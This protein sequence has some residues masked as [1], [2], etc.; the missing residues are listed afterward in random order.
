MLTYF[1]ERDR[2]RARKGQREREIQNWSR[3]QALS[4]Q[5]RAWHGARTH[6]PGDHDL[7]RSWT[8][9]RLSHPGI[10]VIHL[11]I[12]VV[13]LYI[14]LNFLPTEFVCEQWFF[15]NYFMKVFSGRK[16]KCIFLD[17][18]LVPEI[19]WAH[20]TYWYFTK[21]SLRNVSVYL[22]NSCFVIAFWTL[23]TFPY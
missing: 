3:L 13:Y 7:S 8:P 12:L 11:L 19:W 23:H 17:L 20:F 16:H 2:M 14:L 10:P 18:L 1:W 4:C 9:N 21:S 22:P 6:E 15:Y 5:L